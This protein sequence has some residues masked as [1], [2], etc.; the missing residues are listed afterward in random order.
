MDLELA[1]IHDIVDELANRGSQY[2]IA[3][4]VID[5]GA[6]FKLH[7]CVDGNKDK[8]KIAQSLIGF[9][10]KGQSECWDG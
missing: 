2:I 1:T 6:P 9:F 4:Q 5:N 8:M 3:V 10:D 7:L